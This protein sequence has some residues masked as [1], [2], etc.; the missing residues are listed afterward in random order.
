MSLYYIVPEPTINYLFNNKPITKSIQKN[1]SLIPNIIK[2]NINEE[3]KCEI[4]YIR[5]RRTDANTCSEW[6]QIIQ[7]N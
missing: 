4:T 7:Q 1:K 2:D 6:K 5:I 3:T